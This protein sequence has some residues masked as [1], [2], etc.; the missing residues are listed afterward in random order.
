MKAQTQAL[1]TVLITTVI[2]GAAA[3]TYVWGQPLLDKQQ[4]QTEVEKLE[5]EV[6]NIYSLANSVERSGSGHRSTLDISLPQGTLDIKEDR[7]YIEVTVPASNSPY[8]SRW[9]LLRG[10]TEKNTSI[11]GDDFASEGSPPGI[12]AVRTSPSQATD[13][14]TYRIEFRNV[15]NDERLERTVLKSVGSDTA[16][17]DFT[18]ALTNKGRRTDSSYEVSSGDSFRLDKTIIEVDI[19]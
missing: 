14:I 11:G 4:S 10:G 9:T 5:R 8:A 2:I 3:S 15:K 19:Q 17:G 7:N 1:T 12:V 6:L 16:T 18:L 13:T